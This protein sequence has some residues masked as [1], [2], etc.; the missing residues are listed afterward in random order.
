MQISMQI[1]DASPMTSLLRIFIL[2]L[3]RKRTDIMPASKS[4]DAAVVKV[5]SNLFPANEKLK[6]NISIA[7]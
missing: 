3:T 1:T 7:V 4:G 2:P 6:F 5:V